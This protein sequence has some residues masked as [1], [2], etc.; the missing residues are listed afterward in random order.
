MSDPNA[1]FS[2]TRAVSEAHAFDVAA[3]QAWLS[4]HLKGFEGPVSVEMFKGGQSNPTYKLITPARSYVMR[5]K[6]GPVAKLLPSAHAIEREFRVTAALAAR[7]SLCSDRP[8]ASMVTIAG[9]RSTH[10]CQI[11]SG[12]P[13]S[14]QSTPSTRVMRWA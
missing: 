8:W 10:R 9:K 1:T 3:M 7:T 11:A 13:R 14:I 5:A 12:L 6:P 2:G 4:G